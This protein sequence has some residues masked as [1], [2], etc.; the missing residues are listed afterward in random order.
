MYLVKLLQLAKKYDIHGARE[1]ALDLLYHHKDLSPGQK[2]VVAVQHEAIGW[3]QSAVVEMVQAP[4]NAVTEDESWGM[5]KAY[6]TVVQCKAA[7]EAFRND[8]AYHSASS[9]KNGTF[10]NIDQRARCEKGWK[11]IVWW[12][13]VAR[14]LLAGGPNPLSMESI[15]E[16]LFSV[17]Y[18]AVGEVLCLSCFES[19][20]DRLK[21]D[22]PWKQ[23]ERLIENAVARI[24]LLSISQS[25]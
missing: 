10:C 25:Y 12:G 9:Y 8:L 13:R 21:A 6:H 20:V 1:R 17:P 3:I 2:L 16:K 19:S 11:D 5:G 22:M 15:F 18:A 7:L 23:E 14:L 4:W 24:Q